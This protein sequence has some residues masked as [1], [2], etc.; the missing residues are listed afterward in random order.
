VRESARKEEPL[1]L[2]VFDRTAG[3]LS[4]AWRAGAQLYRARG[5][6]DS[7]RGARSWDEALEHLEGIDPE[8]PISEIQFWGHGKWGNAQLGGERLDAGS[9][10]RGHPLGQ[11]LRRIARRFDDRALFWFRTCETVGA[12]AG[13]SF[14]RAFSHELGCRVAG[15]TYAIDALQS[16]LHALGPGE[17]PDWDPGEGLKE[18][19][20]ERPVRAKRS[21]PSAPRTITCFEGVLPDWA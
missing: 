16:G 15:H 11:R 10:S 7:A 4:W 3:G 21:S 12:Q 20:P 17:E 9:L 1:R 5:L 8:R 19:T 13:Q 6:I 2:L 18:G 14:A